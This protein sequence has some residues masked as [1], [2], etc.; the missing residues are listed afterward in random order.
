MTSCRLSKTFYYVF[1]FINLQLECFCM[2]V[3]LA[4]IKFSASIIGGIK[5]FQTEPCGQTGFQS[6]MITCT[7]LQILLSVP[8]HIKRGSNLVVLNDSC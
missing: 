4:I 1:A 6:Q 3:N 8:T 2:A 5:I 7:I